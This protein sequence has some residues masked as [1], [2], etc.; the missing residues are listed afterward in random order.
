VVF[1]QLE[2][3]ARTRRV[4]TIRDTKR[5]FSAGPVSGAGRINTCTPA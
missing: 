2:F 1:D 4:G 5:D 3:V